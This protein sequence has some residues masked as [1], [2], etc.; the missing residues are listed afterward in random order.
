MYDYITRAQ[1][2]E[3]LS[4][5]RFLLCLWCKKNNNT[6][7]L[8]WL[9]VFNQRILCNVFCDYYHNIFHN[10]IRIVMTS[11]LWMILFGLFCLA[12]K[13]GILI[14]IAKTQCTIDCYYRLWFFFSFR[15]HNLPD[16]CLHNND[17]YSSKYLLFKISSKCWSTTSIA[18]NSIHPAQDVSRYGLVT[19]ELLTVW[20]IV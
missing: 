13:H 3:N 4:V 5:G 17:I 12:W 19:I 14:I 2:T 1:R 20:H 18:I 15:N 7:I 8:H 6:E 16:H 10:K 11:I 9:G